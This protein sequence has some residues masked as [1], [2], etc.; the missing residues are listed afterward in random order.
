M[1][2]YHAI[3]REEERERLLL[4][5]FDYNI[6]GVVGELLESSTFES[7]TLGKL[8][9]D[10][11]TITEEI[12]KSTSPK[13]AKTLLKDL[14]HVPEELKYELRVDFINEDRIDA[15]ALRREFFELLLKQ[16][17]ANMFEG[18]ENRRIPKKDS[19]LE[20]MFHTAGIIIAHSIL[21]GGPG[22]PCLCPAA[23]HYLL[24]LD[25]EKV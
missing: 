18:H 21:Q 7:S 10:H 1:V 15:G 3:S 12:C 8:T 2:L 22:F 16:L 24:H 20:Q 17:I 5:R 13:S 4:N 9:D 23:Y 6:H 25:K 19:S 11:S 14:I